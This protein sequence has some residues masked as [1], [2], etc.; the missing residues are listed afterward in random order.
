VGQ[1]AQVKLKRDFIFVL[2]F[3]IYLFVWDRS[4]EEID[5]LT[6]RSKFAEEAFLAMYRKLFDVPDPVHALQTVLVSLKTCSPTTKIV[7][8]QHDHT[9]YLHIGS[10]RSQYHPHT[11]VIIAFNFI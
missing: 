11:F 7:F 1:L 5:S 6:K 2:D 4:Q 8:N 10:F 9:N 3:Y